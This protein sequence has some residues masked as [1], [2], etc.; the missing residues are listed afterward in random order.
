MRFITVAGMCFTTALAGSL[1]FSRYG[2][3]DAPVA[4]VLEHTQ[5]SIGLGF[6]A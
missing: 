3:I 1:P 5:A 2:M 6:T 4:D